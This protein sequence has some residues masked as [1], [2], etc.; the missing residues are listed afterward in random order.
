MTIKPDFNYLVADYYDTREG[1]SIWI[2]ISLSDNK[3]KDLETFKKFIG[4]E[5]FFPSIEEIS[6]NDFWSRYARM[7]PYFVS[8]MIQARKECSFLWQRQ[9]RLHYNAA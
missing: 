3:H 8:G 6:S 7:V 9:T 1:H 4:E 5:F 2:Q